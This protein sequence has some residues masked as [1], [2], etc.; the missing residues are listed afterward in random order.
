M[1]A[2]RAT[3]RTLLALAA[4][5]FGVAAGGVA[6][7]A[8]G[9]VIL[10]DTSVSQ[11]QETATAVKARLDDV[12]VVDLSVD[13]PVAA[14]RRARPRVIVA[15]GQKALTTLAGRVEDVPIVYATVLFPEKHGLTGDN[16]TGVP[17]EVPAAT[18]LAR[19]KQV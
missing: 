16:I 8:G 7:A 19:F 12:T 15:I 11:Y 10:V 5:L 1:T 2:S 13:D 18:Q 14:A 17:L 4:C 6:R 9:T 3:L